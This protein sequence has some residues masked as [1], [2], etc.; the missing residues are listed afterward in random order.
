MITDSFGK[1]NP[2][3]PEHLLAII[4]FGVPIVGLMKSNQ[5]GHDLTHRQRTSSLAL[6]LPARQ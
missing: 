4:G 3:V 1:L 6:L 2:P 5:H